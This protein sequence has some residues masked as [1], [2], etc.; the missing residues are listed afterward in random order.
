MKFDYQQ[1]LRHQGI[2][3]HG[4]VVMS[5]INHR[6][7]YIYVDHSLDT[8]RQTLVYKI[9]HSVTQSAIAA[10]I[11]AM[12]TGSRVLMSQEVWH[13]FQRTGTSHLIAISGLHVSLVAAL[14]YALF[15]YLWKRSE[16]LLLRF[17]A[18]Q[19]ALLASLLG[20]LIYSLLAGFTIPTQR[21]M[22]MLLA[23]TLGQLANKNVSLWVRW[24]FAFTLVLVWWPESIYSVS[25]WLSFYAVFCLGLLVNGRLIVGHEKLAWFRV[26]FGMFLGLLPISLWYFQQTS[27]VMLLANL[28][29]IPY[30]SFIVVPSCL[31]AIV[32]YFISAQYS[33]WLWWVAEKSLEP[34]W[35]Y[36]QHL[37]NWKYALWHHP[38]SHAWVLACGILAMLLFIA[39]RGFPC[40]R[41]GWVFCL[42]MVL[43]K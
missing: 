43:M 12:S 8:I 33:E 19:I 20:A 38:L 1:W 42:P 24:I 32:G 13:V 7:H 41:L 15:L 35:W 39:P 6:N 17:P 36:L 29:A 27:T 5:K 21:A 9:K 10:I 31:L 25:F 40:R 18:Q 22:L 30:V 14:V 2:S 11:V 16:F 28:V 23:L 3:A 26:Q 34:L 37:A 4:Y